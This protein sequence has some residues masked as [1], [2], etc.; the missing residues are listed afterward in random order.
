MDAWADRFAKCAVDASGYLV[1][2]VKSGGCTAVDAPR[3]S[4]TALASYAIGFAHAGL[5]RRLC[6]ALAG[7]GRVTLLGLGGIREYAEGFSGKGDANAGPI[8][9]GVSVGATGFGLGAA[10]MNGDR[11]L[12]RQLYRSARLLGVPVETEGGESFALGGVLGNAL[13]LAMLTARAP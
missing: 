5:S 6:E 4:G 2:R 12:Y 11:E 9:L 1:Q 10:R 13:L 8:V 3:G 7:P